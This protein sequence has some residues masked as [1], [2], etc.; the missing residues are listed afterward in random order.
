MPG[1]PIETE[2]PRTVGPKKPGRK[3]KEPVEQQQEEV[4]SPPVKRS[5]RLQAI[6]EQPQKENV[7]PIEP[8]QT[9]G[10]PAAGEQHPISAE[11]AVFGQSASENPQTPHH[12]V[13]Q[14]SGLENL[15][16]D[17][18]NP[19]NEMTNFGYTGEGAPTPGAVS[20]GG[21]TP[22][23]Y[24]KALFICTLIS[25]IFLFSAFIF[26]YFYRD[27]DYYNPASMASIKAAEE[28]QMQDG[29][30]IE[31]F[32][33]RV[34]NKR[35]GHLNHLLQAKLQDSMSLHFSELTRRNIRKQAA[36]KFY[37]ML[38]LQKVTAVNIDQ[39]DAF[40]PIMITKGPNFDKCVL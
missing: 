11:D 17:Q 27:D 34:L 35:A 39:A 16:Y 24:I 19:N 13:Q 26:I 7:P 5:S 15:G 3:R 29:E 40:G 22:Y 6:Q 18:T 10:G 12:Q 23:R 37:S 4:V 8:P 28:E 31:E 20:M 14:P 30:T 32:E 33:D 36:Q 38:V 1:G 21:A 25:R 9:P 2:D